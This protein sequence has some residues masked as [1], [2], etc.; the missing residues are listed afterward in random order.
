MSRDVI[1]VGGGV[2]G[3][4]IALRLAREG[5]KV[6]LIERGRV[7]CEASRAAAGMLSPQAEA[8]EPGPF[9][10]LCLRS[11]ALY[12]EFARL[13]EDL[14]GVD[15]EYRDEGTLCV[16]LA[17]EDPNQI[18]RWAAWQ[19]SVALPL[20]ELLAADIAVLEPAVTKQAA[21]AVFVPGDHQVENRRLMD[22]LDS[23]IRR[24]GVE[25]IEGAEVHRL[26]VERDRATGV[27]CGHAPISAGAV[28]VAAGSWSSRL[29]DPVGLRVRVVP[30]RGQM[31]AVRG[32]TTMR[33]VL[34]SSRVYLVP[35]RDGRIVV[36]AT[37]EYVGFNKAVTAGGI[38]GL[39]DAAIEMVPSLNDAE[40]IETWAGFRPDTEDHLPVIGPCAVAGL[41]LATGHFR[42][43]I[44]L[45]PVTAELV[46][47]CV[48]EQTLAD[49]L[50]P[51]TINRF[52]E[53]PIAG[54]IQSA[55]SSPF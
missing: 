6:T 21:R 16:A 30:A 23:A 20:E 47:R 40:I 29:L 45:A 39:L 33:H 48:V 13:L 14:S 49:E 1:I 38:R 54:S 5:L 55:I 34:H 35:R 3:G 8:S 43:G 52:D 11:R 53:R 17:G 28:I 9:L 12:P 7:G 46:A 37:V 10:D 25:V 31:L 27:V 2:I 50:R 19:K 22:A 51:F 24:A 41:F 36:G 44:L 26:I 15:I 18:A 32:A 4:S 42:N